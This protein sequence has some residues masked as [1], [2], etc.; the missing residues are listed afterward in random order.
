MPSNFC[1]RACPEIGS[2]ALSVQPREAYTSYNVWI[3]PLE[4][5]S[6]LK[7]F[8]GSVTGLEHDQTS[9]DL[10]GRSALPGWTCTESAEEPIS[11]Q[12]DTRF[13]RSSVQGYSRL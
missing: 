4:S 9:R 12:R 1:C 5:S 8:D 11:V 3:L 10:Q 7:G 2:S 13:G 6:Q